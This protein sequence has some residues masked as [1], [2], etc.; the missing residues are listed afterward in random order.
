MCAVVCKSNTLAVSN[1]IDSLESETHALFAL[2]A[3]GAVQEP[4]VF[5]EVLQSILQHTC[6][7]FEC[8]VC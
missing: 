4:E 8:V 1:N 3:L 7:A 2:P 6:N 5:K